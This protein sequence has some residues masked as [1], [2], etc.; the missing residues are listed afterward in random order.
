MIVAPNVKDQIPGAVIGLLLADHSA[1]GLVHAEAA[2]PKISDGLSEMSGQIFL[3]R[4]AVAD[5]MAK[6]EAVAIRVDPA[7]LVHILVR[8]THAVGP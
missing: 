8:S 1:V 3:P 5:L 4:L 7:G 6:R 2:H